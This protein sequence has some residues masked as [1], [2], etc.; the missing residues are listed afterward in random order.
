MSLFSAVRCL[1]ISIL[2]SFT[3]M[4]KS[5]VDNKPH[6]PNAE[7]CENYENLPF[8]GLQNPPTKVRV[9]SL[10]FT[11]CRLLTLIA[12]VTSSPAP[13]CLPLDHLSMPLAVCVCVFACFSVDY[14]FSCFPLVDSHSESRK[15]FNP[16]QSYPLMLRLTCSLSP[17]PSNSFLSIDFNPIAVI[18][19]VNVL[20]L[21][22]IEIVFLLFHCWYLR[23]FI[24][25]VVRHPFCPPHPPHI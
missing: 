8:H 18:V 24:N 15:S 17:P 14:R 2:G 4:E 22:F 1:L 11:H 10:L 16:L 21:L 3:G 9:I 25:F 5:L 6:D 23:V 19:F 12:L 7:P 20:L 13:M